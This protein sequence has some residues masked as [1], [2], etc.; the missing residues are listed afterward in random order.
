M[1]LYVFWPKGKSSFIWHLF[2]SVYAYF[3]FSIYWKFLANKNLCDGWPRRCHSD[4][5]HSLLV[6]TSV[7]DCGYDA[8][9]RQHISYLDAILLTHLDED[10]AGGV[11]VYGFG[12]VSRSGVGGEG[13]T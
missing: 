3:R 2:D 9:E 6:D 8:L 11:E 10:H 13:I 1:A 12:S 7:G 4:N 5:K